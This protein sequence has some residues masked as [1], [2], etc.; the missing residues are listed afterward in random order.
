MKTRSLT[1]MTGIL[2]LSVVGA[3]MTP[4]FAA[5]DVSANLGIV[6]NYYFRGV[7][8]TLDATAVQGGLDYASDAGFYAG[9][10]ASNV[11]F[12]D[13]TSYEID[14]YAG[15]GGEVSG[16]AYDVGYIYY[17]YPDSPSSIDFG[18]VYGELGLGPFAV[19]FAYTTNSEADDS[20]F[21]EGDV[22]YYGSFAIPL[23]DGYGLGVSAGYY[24]FDEDGEPALDGADASYSH[25]SA[26]L[27][28]DVGEFGEV[29]FNLE[30][31]DIDED[32]AL[33]SDNSDDLKLWLGWSKSF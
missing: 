2:G 11:D 13:G 27:A 10:W 33:G 28:K 20:T 31:A 21:V 3:L 26:S 4:S 29:S 6:S 32:D 15:F 14:L 18:E 25:V 19:G 7:T 12:D 24:D 23:A 5:A 9:T 1:G 17:G 22:Y 16:L 8:Q 30:L